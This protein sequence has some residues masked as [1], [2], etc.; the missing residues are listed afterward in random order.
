MSV[1]F[2]YD[3]GFLDR[4]GGLESTAEIVIRNVFTILSRAFRDVRSLTT[5]IDTELLGIEH[6]TGQTMVA[7]QASIE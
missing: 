5:Y 4:F 2:Y 1:Y 6:L 3:D 7:D